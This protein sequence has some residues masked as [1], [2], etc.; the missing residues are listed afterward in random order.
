MK[1]RKLRVAVVL[2]VL[3]VPAYL[4]LLVERATPSGVFTLDV[5]ELRRLPNELP[6]DKPT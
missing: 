3:A 2:L 5:A 6:G 4:W 1:S